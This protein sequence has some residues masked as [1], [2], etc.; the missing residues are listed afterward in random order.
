MKKKRFII[1]NTVYIIVT[2]ADIG[3]TYYVSPDL[4]MEDNFAVKDLGFGWEAVLFIAM[5]SIIAMLSVTYY[6]CFRYKTVCINSSK[7]TQ[8]YSLICFD[9]PDKFWTGF[10]PK[11]IKPEIAAA[12]FS[13]P[14]TMSFYRL[15][16][17]CEWIVIYLKSENDFIYRFLRA[18][19]L[20][21][22]VSVMLAISLYYLWFYIE[23]K[24]SLT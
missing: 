6:D 15:W 14:W 7:Y 8:Y 2:L 11:H 3:V 21:E 4:S 5:M 18:E 16:C 1:T 19:Y 20:A 13:L 24:K 10:T 17:V 12:G 22:T 23:Y 9:E